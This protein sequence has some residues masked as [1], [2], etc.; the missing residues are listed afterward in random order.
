MTCEN[1]VGVKNILISFKDCD[2]DVDDGSHWPMNLPRIS[3]DL[4]T[5]ALTPTKP[6]IKGMLSWL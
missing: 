1:Q 3:S 5:S 6:C 4:A 2:T